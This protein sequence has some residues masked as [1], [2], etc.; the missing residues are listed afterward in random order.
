[1]HSSS[2][3]L[4]DLVPLRS[5]QQNAVE[6]DDDNTV[7]LEGAHGEEVVR[8]VCYGDGTSPNVFTAGEDGH[9]RAWRLP[10]EATYR[11]GSI[12][13]IDERHKSSNRGD[14]EFGKRKEKPGSG[15]GPASRF[16]P[17]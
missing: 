5:K 7:R 3:N 15:K 2:R 17:Y 4:L 9:V 12:A 14:D 1:M 11:E 6:F 13:Q 16:K 10:D 8:S